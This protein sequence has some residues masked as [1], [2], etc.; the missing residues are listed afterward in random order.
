MSLKCK[1]IFNNYMIKTSSFQTL[2]GIYFSTLIF[3]IINKD[4]IKTNRCLK[5]IVN[6][7]KSWLNS[8]PFLP[9]SIDAF[10]LRKVSK[11]MI[12]VSVTTIF[13]YQLLGKNQKNIKGT[14]IW[15]IHLTAKYTFPLNFPKTVSRLVKLFK[16]IQKI[17]WISPLRATWK[18]VGTKDQTPCI[19]NKRG[20]V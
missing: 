8:Y 10:S 6:I 18:T 3:W 1:S 17:I 15:S 4:L 7:F 5:V 9:R 20:Q 2:L 13:M 12:L 16:D 14:Y 19:R 11:L